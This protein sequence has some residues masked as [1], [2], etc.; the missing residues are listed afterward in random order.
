MDSSF[1]YMDT[2]YTLNGCSDADS[3]LSFEEPSGTCPGVAQS[4]LFIILHSRNSLKCFLYSFSSKNFS[5][6]LIKHVLKIHLEQW[7]F[8][9]S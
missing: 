4:L 9:K 5:I 6:F 2:Q 7:H 1:I 8:F 3:L